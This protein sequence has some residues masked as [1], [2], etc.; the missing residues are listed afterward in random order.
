M[1]I[2]Y[3]TQPSHILL[4]IDHTC[5]LPFA[6]F[7]ENTRYMKKPPSAI[8]PVPGRAGALSMGTGTEVSSTKVTLARLRHRA[9]VFPQFSVDF[10]LVI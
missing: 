4:K 5:L 2:S 6:V 9:Q 3:S 7:R 1:Q 10:G 8:Y